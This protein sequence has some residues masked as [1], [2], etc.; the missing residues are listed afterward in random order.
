MSVVL[1]MFV[2]DGVC[3]F[4]CVSRPSFLLSVSCL[5][6]EWKSE[7]EDTHAVSPTLFGSEKF[8]LMSE[9]EILT[10]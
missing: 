1:Y 3:S 5:H 8:N 4:V 9:I 7:V 2:F 6:L 10:L